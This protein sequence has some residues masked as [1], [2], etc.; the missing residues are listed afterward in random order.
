MTFATLTLALALSATAAAAQVPPAAPAQPARPA[1]P[2]MPARPVVPAQPAV[3]FDIAVSAAIERAMI[4]AEAAMAAMPAIAAMPSMEAM[5]AQFA[6]ADVALARAGDHFAGFPVDFSSSMAAADM[7]RAE[8]AMTADRWGGQSA[9]ASRDR[10]NASYERGRSALDRR[11]WED[12]IMRFSDVAEMKGARADAALY[13]KAYAQSRAGKSAEAQ[14]TISALRSGY[15]QSRYLNDANAL[16]V[17]LKRGGGQQVSPEAQQ[18]ED[19]KLL[20][21]QGLQHSDPEQAIP[22][23]EKILNS[24]NGPRVKERALYVLALSDSAR[25][26]DI[27]LAIGKGG[28]NPDLQRKAIDYLA[29]HTGGEGRAMLEDIYRTNPDQDV[30]MRVL[31]AY[32]T[33]GDRPR[34]LNAARSE[35]NPELRLAA[36]RYLGSS[37]GTTELAELYE[38]ETSKDIRVQIVRSLGAA[39]AVDRLQQIARTEKDP[40]VRLQVIRAF[41]SAGRERTGTTLRDMYANETTPEGKRAIVSAL[42]SQNDADGLVA[43]ARRENDPKL[44]EDLVRRLSTMTKSKVALEYLMELLNK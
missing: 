17:E 42:H 29:T 38:R 1:R 7:A 8:I 11:N 21:I 14:A 36:I 37:G 27:L 13:W 3:P 40:D 16:E 12:A 39:G 34:L 15:A 44:K 35:Q 33:N 43:I 20:A 4:E 24:A 2:T 41:G 6:E 31:R 5:T 28:G 23:L 30:R 18:D 10:E 25:A 19:L 9:S 26:R 22:L 32:M